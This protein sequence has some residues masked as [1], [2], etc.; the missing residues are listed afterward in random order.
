MGVHGI[1]TALPGIPPVI[2]CTLVGLPRLHRAAVK[3]SSYALRFLFHK[4]AWPF[5]GFRKLSGRCREPGFYSGFGICF[6]KH[7]AS[8]IWDVRRLVRPSNSRRFCDVPSD[9]NPRQAVS[10]LQSPSRGALPTCFFR[11]K[12][13]QGL[14][15]VATIQ[16]PNKLRRQVERGKV[17]RAPNLRLRITRSKP[18]ARLL[19]VAT[20]A[21]LPR[22]ISFHPSNF[23]QVCFTPP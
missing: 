18:A 4:S 15:R 2:V 9:T 12:A 11:H 13:R 3:L 1:Y 23:F 7:C 10:P 6:A 14:C 21:P 17:R 8:L 16:P 20:S 22:K 5:V 19:K